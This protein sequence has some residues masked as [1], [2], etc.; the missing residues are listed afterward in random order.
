MPCT[1]SAVI[2]PRATHRRVGRLSVALFSAGIVA[3]C[4]AVRDRAPGD[5]GGGA[6]ATVASARATPLPTVTSTPGVAPLK[7]LPAPR[8]V[9]SWAEVRKQAAERMVAANAEITYLGKVPDM[10]LAIPVLE[11]ELNGDG[12]VRKIEVLREPREAKDTL[13]IAADAVRRAG[14]FGN[15]AKLPKPWKFIETFLFNDARKFKPRTLDH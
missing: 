10:L 6:P 13:Q 5:T 11:I 12:S 14:P 7:S 2:A 4:A 15:V 1:D 3:G 9:A 8:P